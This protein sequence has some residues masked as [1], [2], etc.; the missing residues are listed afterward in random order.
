MPF[1]ALLGI[2]FFTVEI[3]GLAWL[4]YWLLTHSEHLLIICLVLFVALTLSALAIAAVVVAGRADEGMDDGLIDVEQCAPSGALAIGRGS[5]V[6][7]GSVPDVP[8]KTE[9]AGPYLE[10]V[11]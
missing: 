8:V 7:H 4:L 5:A 11:V 9:T 1:G 2:G 3:I 6:K 10:A